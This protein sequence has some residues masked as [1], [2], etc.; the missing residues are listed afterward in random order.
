MLV[1]IDMDGNG[2]IK[3][4]GYARFDLSEALNDGIQSRIESI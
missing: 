4:G 2:T 1:I 3:N